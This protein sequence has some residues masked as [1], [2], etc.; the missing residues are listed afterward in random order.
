[1]AQVQVAALNEALLDAFRDRA[2]LKRMLRLQL[3]KRLDHLSA[4]AQLQPDVVLDVIEA[5]ESGGWLE[6]LIEAA[7]RANPGNP[8][9]REFV[10]S[11]RPNLVHLFME[12]QTSTLSPSRAWG[13]TSA[14]VERARFDELLGALTD[15]GLKPIREAARAGRLHD[16]IQDLDDLLNTERGDL[17][18]PQRA[19]LLRLRASYEL[20]V[21]GDLERV[22]AWLKHAQ[23]VYHDDADELILETRVLLRQEGI[24]AALVH[25]QSA[26]ALA[27]PGAI[28][29]EVRHLHVGLLTEAGEIA[30]AADALLKIEAPDAETHRLRALVALEQRDLV[31]A[32]EAIEQAVSS[33]P[34]GELV[35]FVEAIVEFWEVVGPQ[36]LAHADVFWPAPIQP[37]LLRVDAEALRTLQRVERALSELAEL[38]N[39]QRPIYVGWTVALRCL[40]SVR[41]YAMTNWHEQATELAQRV[42]LETPTHS[43]IVVWAV[44][45]RLGVDF[46]DLGQRLQGIVDTNAL[47]RAG[48]E[49]ILWTAV[50]TKK[51]GEALKVLNAHRGLF[52][53]EAE[54]AWLSWQAR[55]MV[56]AGEPETALALLEGRTDLWRERAMALQSNYK[57]EERRTKLVELFEETGEVEILWDV[58]WMAAQDQDWQGVEAHVASLTQSF[59]IPMAFRMAVLSAYNL[60]R[61]ELALERLHDYD[62]HVR[63]ERPP[64][65]FEVEAMASAALGRVQ[66]ALAALDRIE[67]RG[68]DRIFLHIEVHLALHD[69]RQVAVLAQHLSSEPE[70]SPFRLVRLIAVLVDEDHP[71]AVLFWRRLV[72]NIEHTPDA[73]VIPL[74]SLGFR[75]GLP[76]REVERVLTRAAQLAEAGRVPLQRL[77][78]ETVVE[79]LGERRDALDPL[80][81][82]YL[83]AQVPVHVLPNLWTMAAYCWMYPDTNAREATPVRQ[84]PVLVRFGGMSLA[85]PVPAAV[86]RMQLRA[87]VTA[88]LLASWLG[89]LDA[90]EAHFKPIACSPS[91][92]P[93][94]LALE[95]DLRHHQPARRAGVDKT[96]GLIDCG[97]L[98]RCTTAEP[99]PPALDGLVEEMGR[100]WVVA[101]LECERRGGLLVDFLPLRHGV[102]FQ[103]PLH[104]EPDLAAHVVDLPAV[105]EGL[106]R[107]GPLSGDRLQKALKELGRYPLTDGR[108][109][110][111]GTVV[112]LTGAIAELLASV[113][114][115][116]MAADCFSL[117]IV[118]RDLDRLRAEHAEARGREDAAGAVE[119]LAER[120]RDGLQQ[121]IYIPLPRS[122][123]RSEEDD[124]RWR[125]LVDL[126][127][128]LSPQVA[129]WADDRCIHRLRDSSPSPHWTSVEVLM[130]LR[131]A[132]AVDDD[133]F[134]EAMLKLR[135]ANA[136]FIPLLGDEL[137]YHLANAHVRAD[138]VLAETEPLR[139]LRRSYNAALQGTFLLRK[140]DEVDEKHEGMFLLD[141]HRACDFALTRIWRGVDGEEARRGAEARSDW[142]VRSVHLGLDH[143]MDAVGWPN[144]QHERLQLARTSLLMLVT[145]A[146]GLEDDV[147]E[148]YFT[149]LQS[150]VLA[151]RL[152]NAPA[153]Q[154]LLVESIR[155]YVMQLLDGPVNEERE[156][157]VEVLPHWVLALPSGLRDDVL[158]TSVA[159]LFGLTH[160]RRLLIGGH[161]FELG[162]AFLALAEVVNGRVTTIESAAPESRS[163]TFHPLEEGSP[164]FWSDDFAE[165]RV[166]VQHASWALLLEDTQSREREL[167][168]LRLARDLTREEILEVEELSRTAPERGVRQLETL[169]SEAAHVFFP[170]IRGTLLAKRQLN[171]RELL[172]AR[173]LLLAR[174]LRLSSSAAGERSWQDAVHQLLEEVGVEEASLRLA[175]LPVALGGAVEQAFVLAGEEV[176]TRVVGRLSG[177]DRSVVALVHAMRLTRISQASPKVLR[178]VIAAFHAELVASWGAFDAVMRWSCGELACRAELLN[179]GIDHV[180]ALGWLATHRLQVA[181]RPALENDAT[182]IERAFR[183][184]EASRVDLSFITHPALRSD[185]AHPDNFDRGTFLLGALEYALGEGGIA[186]LSEDET[187]LLREGI[188]ANIDGEEVLQVSMRRDQTLGDDGLGSFLAGD[189]LRVLSRLEGADFE[190]RDWSESVANDVRLALQVLKSD[191]TNFVSW[192]AL[193]LGVGTYPIH[194][195]HAETFVQVMKA[196]DFVSWIERDAVLG[197]EFLA[198]ACIQAQ[199]LCD[200]ELMAHTRGAL[201]DLARRCDARFDQRASDEAVAVR[202]ALLVGAL[203]WAGCSGT[204]SRV[205]AFC[206]LIREVVL[207]HS[208]MASQVRFA[209]QAMG[210]ELPRE[211]TAPVWPL[212]VWMRGVE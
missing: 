152:R 165:H 210:D 8:R 200:H 186:M 138:G 166:D 78:L 194:T 117:E 61:F 40:L 12:P 106:H 198:L 33:T 109:P 81:Q 116:E 141:S 188:Y 26:I 37:G 123:K 90:V 201:V 85:D 157:M 113:D 160:A 36:P 119:R 46:N 25:I 3:D 2:A 167:E 84:L 144:V 73:L 137:L 185:V 10:N 18:S 70:L 193:R 146:I 175:A 135:R 50:A 133:T 19:R 95:N 149:W 171:L 132:G 62:T 207:A 159:E 60:G 39:G 71:L 189:R 41:D 82:R 115:L 11:S 174:H 176:R 136:R 197:V 87:D 76:E 29:R 183:S 6:Q 148:A 72:D 145:G 9:L 42:L 125:C 5:A 58:C 28:T 88:L 122:P 190:G 93:L 182:G 80:I 184:N 7:V 32:R 100:P 120:L 101:L 161:E 211:T 31:T 153:L 163:F 67:P 75:L 59:P 118:E 4:P 172:P 108:V 196:V 69:L 21:D 127:E 66:D 110:S 205:A 55:L 162:R 112:C 147:A 179:A 158:E 143:A 130:V 134:F 24:R 27:S 56:L 204:G 142:L 16:A 64:E 126:L 45:F 52:E 17:P 187:Q 111:A 79:L 168:R 30:A 102:N 1:V 48:L 20:A 169:S 180:L 173:T 91:V 105:L 140:P 57:G 103:P 150:A 121:G 99:V 139:V 203:L 107:A 192:A 154:P 49:A 35:R 209:L 177:E 65:L 44:A 131:V 202:H 181:L 83:R 191:E 54:L 155:A 63:E 124:P 15:A 43:Y 195:A 128:N 97:K 23:E 92:L 14:A 98:R 208:A 178:S 104:L 13:A 151:A 51:P 199:H 47:D 77:T 206:D 170:K 22:K 114:L 86:A 94:L 38:N 53:E 89:I 156:A 164:G 68:Q 129:V 74:L 212:L 96:L 34:D